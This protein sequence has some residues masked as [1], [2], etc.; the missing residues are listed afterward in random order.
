MHTNKDSSPFRKRIRI[1][2]GNYSDPGLYFL[3]SCSFGNALLFGNVQD[4][5]LLM[6]S[7]GKMIS[8]WWERLP[9]KF[10]RIELREFIVMP[11]HFHG[12]IVIGREEPRMDEKREEPRMELGREEPRLLPYGMAFGEE[13]GFDTR[14][15]PSIPRIM[16]WF[17]TMS[18]NEFLR[19]QKETG[20]T[21]S[22][23]LWQ[24][25]YYDHI[26]RNDTDY[27]RISEYIKNNPGKWMADRFHP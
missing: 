9:G 20:A 11:N 2:T 3:T 5:S 1:S 15:E 7:V 18:T 14:V 25:S 16:Q 12:I 19:I 23:R 27:C 10:L 22:P 13:M 4:N 21:N 24:R 26:I 17:K 6:N 8:R